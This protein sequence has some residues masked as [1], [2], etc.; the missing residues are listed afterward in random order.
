MEILILHV[1]HQVY[2]PEIVLHHLVGIP[3]EGA[4]EFV[5]TEV[6]PLYLLDYAEKLLAKTV[7]CLRHL[8]H[9][10]EMVLREAE[11]IIVGI[12]LVGEDTMI[13]FILF[14]QLPLSSL[15]GHVEGLFVPRDSMMALLVAAVMVVCQ[16]SV[17]DTI[18]LL[19]SNHIHIDF[20]DG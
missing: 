13:L 18:V 11:L 3:Q 4:K 9:P 8:A 7:L 10:F 20:I 5:V 1:I 17:K 14:L 19:R 15:V 12:L 2:Q 16:L 6:L